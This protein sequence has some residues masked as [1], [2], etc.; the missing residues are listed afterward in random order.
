MA[1][2]LPFRL[3][4][5]V[6]VLTLATT[7]CTTV[8]PNYTGA[9]PVAGDAS[10]RGAFLRA[11]EAV[12][13]A[14]AARWWEALNDPALTTLIDDALTQSPNVAIA[15]AKISQA[16][17]GLAATKTA[18]LPTIGTSASAPYINIPENVVNPGADNGDR[19]DI[20][21][22]STGFD[23]SW[24]LD[25]FGGTRRKIESASAK[26]EAAKAGL[27][28]A[29]VALSAEVARAYVGLR[30][31]QAMIAV[32]ARQRAIDADQVQFATQRFQRGT[33][34]EQPLNQARATLAQTE[35]AIGSN[36]AEIQVLSDQLALLT[37]RE[38]GALDALLAA[39]TPI[40]VPPANVAVGDPALLL[41]NR[42]D[43]RIAERQ[44]AAANADVGARVADKFP[45]ISFMGMLGTGGSNVGD[46]FSPSSLIGLILPRISWT[47][48]DGGRAEAQ[49]QAAKGS[50]AEA[51][52]RYRQTVLAALQDAE[53]ALTRFGSQRI[54]W[55]KALDAQQ[56]A[57]RIVALQK[58]RAQGGTISVS[59]ALSAERQALQA[60]AAAINARAEATNDFVAV[61]KALGLGWAL[62]GA[63]R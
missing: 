43:I 51:E 21:A 49:V 47:L 3:R 48:F 25:L 19:R 11:G 34:P 57:D 6:L 30:A 33:A 18:V 27:A 2:K 55:G 54:N 42:P 59:D 36:D 1:M 15:E 16:R 26:A 14:P 61:Q 7:A 31:R 29:Q 58:Q 56:Q 22:F 62:P 38:P 63:A 40:P 35:G 17:A 24:E 37:G 32:L 53:S 23:A 13:Q 9:P 41:R 39:P 50:Y 44:L 5:A 52:A 20:K 4:S 46:M 10:Q 28:D 8:G 12:A 60:R 45:K